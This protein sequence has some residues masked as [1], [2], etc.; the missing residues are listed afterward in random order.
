[1]IRLE[2]EKVGITV[3]QIFES[4]FHEIDTTGG[5]N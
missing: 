4:L 5:R 1:M 3:L 2:K